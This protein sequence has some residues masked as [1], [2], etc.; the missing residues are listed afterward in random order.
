M[1]DNWDF[2]NAPPRRL[3][4]IGL[5][6]IVIM[7]LYLVLWSILI[8]EF[9]VLLV[10]EVMIA[11][12]SCALLFVVYWR[13]PTSIQIMP[14]GFLLRFRFS[15]PR[16]VAWEE[17]RD[18]HIPSVDSSFRNRKRRLASLRLMHNRS[19]YMIGSAIAVEIARSYQLSMGRQ[20][21]SW[22]G[23]AR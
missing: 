3:I 15:R 16:F 2:M 6:A 19:P 23:S 5:A 1:E 14:K 9:M 12:F 18:M 8:G 7:F 20:I 22:D 4:A 10:G 13:T 17:V 11:S 21:P